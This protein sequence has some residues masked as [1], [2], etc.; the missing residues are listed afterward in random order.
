MPCN[1]A[2][3]VRLETF[4]RDQ[5][6]AVDLKTIGGNAAQ[7]RAGEI[8]AHR[9]RLFHRG[10]DDLR[11]TQIG[12]DQPRADQPRVA[13][14]GA[15]EIRIGQIGI[16]QVA[17]KKIRPRQIGTDQRGAAQVHTRELRARRRGVVEQAVAEV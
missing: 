9:H 13:Q 8:G 16:A 2:G 5:P 12:A 15:A 17:A 10:I 11:L 3:Q 7:H 6:R 14:I 1:G 4:G